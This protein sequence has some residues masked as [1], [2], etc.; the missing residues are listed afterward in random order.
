M[1]PMIN[2]KDQLE[3]E[4]QAALAT[5]PQ[6][7]EQYY[8]QNDPDKMST[9]AKT[10]AKAVLSKVQQALELRKHAWENGY[11]KP[12][13]DPRTKTYEM[14][15][16]VIKNL[17]QVISDI[18]TLFVNLYE[19]QVMIKF[20]FTP[21]LQSIL[22]YNPVTKSWNPDKKD[23]AARLLGVKPHDIINFYFKPVTNYKQLDE[24][25]GK[26][27]EYDINLDKQVY[28]K[29]ATALLGKNTHGLLTYLH[30]PTQELNVLWKS[31]CHKSTTCERPC[32]MKKSR[33]GRNYCSNVYTPK[34]SGDVRSKNVIQ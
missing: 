8:N 28:G 19:H 2:I 15:D 13:L 9:V 16:G 21:T 14:E 20:P 3:T 23:E 18:K 11:I 26:V 27:K 29:L 25:F 33:L 22:E 1:G 34:P 24:W 32:G 31:L 7:F 12:Y 10:Y 17:M 4:Q 30:D 6:K 5:I